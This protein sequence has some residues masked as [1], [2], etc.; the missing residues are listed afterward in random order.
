MARDL[1][2]AQRR[3]SRCGVAKPLTE[4]HRRG[5]HY[6]WWCKDCRRVWD[7]RYYAATREIRLSQRRRRSDVLVARMRELKSAPCMDCGVTFHPS[8]MT[9]DHRPGTTKVKDLASLARDGSTRLFE[10]ELEK[11]DLVCANCHALRTF[12]RRE[13]ARLVRGSRPPH[14]AEQ[15]T[16]YKFALAI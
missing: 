15:R 10:R 16:P 13:E 3:C 14:L 12:Q 11:C 5:E 9:F 1:E 8:A 7:A 4:F 2:L 6:Q